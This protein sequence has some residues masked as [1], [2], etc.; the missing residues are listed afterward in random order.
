MP[1]PS[2]GSNDD[3]FDVSSG[4]VPDHDERFGGIASHTNSTLVIG[5]EVAYPSLFAAAA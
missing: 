1:V 3:G 2:F 4:I 5:R